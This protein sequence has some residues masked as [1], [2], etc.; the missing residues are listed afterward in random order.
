MRLLGRVGD[1]LLGLLLRVTEQAL[2]QGVAAAGLVQRAGGLQPHRLGLGLGVGLDLVGVLLGP[3]EQ[4]AALAGS[5]PEPR[6]SATRRSGAGGGG[7]GEGAVRADGPRRRADRPRR[8]ERHRQSVPSP[9]RHGLR[10]DRAW[11][12]PTGA[13]RSPERVAVLHTA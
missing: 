10:P 13:F 12:P 8:S 2:G 7:G 5:S 6:P 11:H 9:C 1:E 3:L 4:A